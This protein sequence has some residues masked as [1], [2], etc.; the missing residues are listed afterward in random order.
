MHHFDKQHKATAFNLSI[1]DVNFHSKEMSQLHSI[2]IFNIWIKNKYLNNFLVAHYKFICKIGLITRYQNIA[3]KNEHACRHIQLYGNA[4]HSV[5]KD[6][7]VSCPFT[8]ATYEGSPYRLEYVAIQE[9]H[10][11]NKRYIFVVP[12]HNFIGRF[13]FSGSSTVS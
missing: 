11:Y 4:S 3:D 1:S 6:L 9:N 12:Y 13:S 10:A 8:D 2:E 5:P 7:Y